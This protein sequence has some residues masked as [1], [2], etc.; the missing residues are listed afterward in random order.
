MKKFLFV[1]VCM[2]LTGCGDNWIV[3]AVPH[4]ADKVEEAPT[5]TYTIDNGQ[6]PG[7]NIDVDA[8]A[9][10]VVD[11]G[12][13]LSGDEDQDAGVVLKVLLCHVPRGNP[14]NRHNISVGEPA[15]SAHL[16]HGDYLGL[17]E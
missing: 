6:L 17:C 12:C 11:A 15:L 14:S 9:V 2:L 10:E 13:P 4:A 1:P 16:A 5:P 3:P 7:D 8:G